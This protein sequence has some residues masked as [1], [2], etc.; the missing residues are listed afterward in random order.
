M[1]PPHLRAALIPYIVRRNWLLRKKPQKTNPKTITLALIQWWKEML[2]FNINGS[3]LFMIMTIQSHST[4]AAPFRMRGIS[5]PIGGCFFFFKKGP[6]MFVC[7]PCFLYML[8]LGFPFYSVSPMCWNSTLALKVRR[9][10]KTPLACRRQFDWTALRTIRRKLFTTLANSRKPHRPSDCWHCPSSVL[11]AISGWNLLLLWSFTD[12]KII[13]P[14]LTQRL[15][16]KSH[17]LVFERANKT[18]AVRLVS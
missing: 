8:F 14:T 2:C 4:S 10:N 9:W 11:S 12:F 16:R 6:R 5:I 15:Q 7:P 17:I 13:S 1:P 3:S 18:T